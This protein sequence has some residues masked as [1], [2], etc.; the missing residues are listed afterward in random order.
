[1]S[2]PFP[3]IFADMKKNI[4]SSVGVLLLLA[5]ACS[6]QFTANAFIRNLIDSAASASDD[7][8]LVVGAPGSK[9]DLVMASVFLRSEESLPLLDGS[10]IGRLE[11][12]PRVA[13]LSPL[14]FADSYQ[15]LPIVGVGEQFPAIRSSLRLA[16]G[17]WPVDTF[18]AVVGADVPLAVG[19]E[20]HSVH[21]GGG[22]AHGHDHDH[23][24]YTVAGKLDRSGTPWDRAIVVPY[25]S[26][27]EVHGYHVHDE[28]GHDGHD[29]VEEGSSDLS[30][31][32]HA[33]VADHDEAAGHD[34]PG[35][36]AIL[37]KPADF[38]SAYAL[39]S[40]YREDGVVSVFPGEI[41]SELF[42]MFHDVQ[43]IAVS[44]GWMTELLVVA[45]VLLSLLA[46]MPSK[47]RWIGLL[48]SLGAGRWYIFF[49][50]WFQSAAV[51]L[52]A[53]LGGLGVGYLAFGRIAA[54]VGSGTG[55]R[56]AMS[57][58]IQDFLFLAIFWG[59]GLI[60]SLIP[61]FVGFRVSPRKVLLGQ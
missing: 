27:W 50:V 8:D 39:R 25:V 12:D 48:R 61:A 44:L 22:N 42:G 31:A 32:L 20:F 54:W 58:S 43:T 18:D 19:D 52:I 55:M 33:S 23:D 4:V 5:F 14:V 13:S 2:N 15:G 40:E 37:V 3:V 51:F 45:A 57:V 6:V 56:I 53:G 49:T 41:L 26:L 11:A 30:A 1:M 9:L 21:E 59:I 34:L 16:D 24:A 38:A 17:T 35:V 29:H 46:S 10:Y 7:Y 60:G 28:Y 47:Y 36:S